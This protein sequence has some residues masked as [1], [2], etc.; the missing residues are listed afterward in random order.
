MREA[1]REETYEQNESSIRFAKE[2]HLVHVRV[3]V[4]SSVTDEVTPV[5]PELRCRAANRGTR[6]TSSYLHLE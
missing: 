3:F 1:T 6:N 2:R 5:P 4:P